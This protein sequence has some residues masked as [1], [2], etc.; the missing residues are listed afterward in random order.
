MC[1]CMSQCP[2]AS[3][4][5]L[6]IFNQTIWLLVCACWVYVPFNFLHNVSKFSLLY[7]QFDELVQQTFQVRIALI[8]RFFK[9]HKCTVAI[10]G[11]VQYHFVCVLYQSFTVGVDILWCILVYWNE[12]PFCA[13]FFLVDLFVVFTLK[14]LFSH[15]YIKVS[16]CPIY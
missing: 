6:N 12:R 14:T 1:V 5:D 11:K 13:S 10:R 8:Y 16:K 4:D 9:L 7:H 2:I 3:S 15:L